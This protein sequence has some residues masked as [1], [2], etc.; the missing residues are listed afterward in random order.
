MSV[1][2]ERHTT[3]PEQDVDA[4]LRESHRLLSLAA[5]VI[6]AFNQESYSTE[7][8]SCVWVAYKICTHIVSCQTLMSRQTNIHGVDI[9][10]TGAISSLERICY[11][12]YMVFFEVFVE[13]H[14]LGKNVFRARFLIWRLKGCHA[15]ML[16]RKEFPNEEPDGAITTPDIEAIMFELN[17]NT[18]FRRDLDQKEISLSDVK[19][20]P[21]LS[22]ST[23]SWKDRCNAANVAYFTFEYLRAQDS[24]SIHA[25]QQ[26]TLLS[27][28]NNSVSA[29][30]FLGVKT[31]LMNMYCILARC[32]LHFEDFSQVNVREI[33]RSDEEIYKKIMYLSDSLSMNQKIVP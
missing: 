24:S 33:L 28:P 19:R 16:M 3:L 23:R 9:P 5:K 17:E 13:G 12:A 10:D 4:A 8:R 21:K 29:A 25:D 7:F 31:A 14:K 22:Y 32:L 1:K 20:I 18:Y 2:T 6:Q 27:A 30:A 15:T 11:E 26:G